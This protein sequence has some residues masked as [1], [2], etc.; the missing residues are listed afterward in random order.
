MP[1][2]MDGVSAA[3]ARGNLRTLETL[4]R[5]TNHPPGLFAEKVLSQGQ[6]HRTT[7]VHLCLAAEFKLLSNPNTDVPNKLLRTA[8]SNQ[9]RILRLLLTVDEAPKKFCPLVHAVHY[10]LVRS[11]GI[12]LEQ[13]DRDA[14][15]M[16]LLETDAYGMNILHVASGAKAPGFAV[17][18]LLG[19]GEGAKRLAGI[20]RQV[21]VDL[22]FEGTNVSVVQLN[23][24]I[25]TR[26]LEMIL[27]AGFGRGA[28]TP[29]EWIDLRDARGRTP[30]H[31]ACRAGRENVVSVL[32]SNGA[33]SMLSEFEGG[34]CGHIAAV[35]GYSNVLNVWKH[36]SPENCMQ[37]LDSFDRSVDELLKLREEPNFVSRVNDTVECHVDDEYHHAK[38][39]WRDFDEGKIHGFAVP[40]FDFAQPPVGKVEAVDVRDLTREV[41][42]ERFESKDLPVLI[43]NASGHWPAYSSINRA[44]TRDRVVRAAGHLKAQIKPMPYDTRKSHAPWMNVNSFISSAF[45]AEH[46][47]IL[48]DSDAQNWSSTISPPPFLFDSGKILQESRLDADLGPPPP[49]FSSTDDDYIVLRQ[50]SISP[51]L[52][53]AH[54][55]FHGPVFNALVVGTRRWALVPPRHAVFSMTPAIDYFGRLR[56]EMVNESSRSPWID[57]VQRAG[58]ILWLPP[59]WQHA[60]LTLADSVAVAFE[61]A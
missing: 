25:G 11:I 23:R 17:R 49:L 27:I 22:T 47:P 13:M 12:L 55:H 43:L 50:L 2:L 54:P 35:R 53:G 56:Y 19:V 20:G 18:I 30:L 41:F 32:L 58:D 1:D 5:A 33:S 9:R 59:Q 51:P 61:S 60:T 7:L 37:S 8:I 6:T 21:D 31:L 34:N 28:L 24:A 16:C 3:V 39:G 40:G 36:A 10:R 46:H 45:T 52:A 4:A 44:W 48:S 26:D 14:L 29:A 42:V 15:R 38:T 57:C